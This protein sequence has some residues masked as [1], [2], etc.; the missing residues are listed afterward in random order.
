VAQFVH[1]LVEAL[2]EPRVVAQQAAQFHLLEL[3]HQ[4]Q[5]GFAGLRRRDAP[6]GV[7]LARPLAAASSRCRTF[8]RLFESAGRRLFGSST[9]CS[10]G[11]VRGLFEHHEKPAA[12]F[13]TPYFSTVYPHPQGVGADP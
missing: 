2:V 1:E 12:L 4:R 8:A 5:R 6:P 3:D 9:R 10:L 13:E 11:R 7:P